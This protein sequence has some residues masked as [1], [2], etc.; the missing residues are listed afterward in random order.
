[1]QQQQPPQSATSP[2]T[3]PGGSQPAPQNAATAGPAGRRFHIAHRRSPSEYT[4]LMRN[5]SLLALADDSGTIC[6]STTDRSPTGSTT[7]SC[8]AITAAA[9]HDAATVVW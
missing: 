6:P 8:I 3:Q 9:I 4:P 7:G 5:S 2:Q 1:M